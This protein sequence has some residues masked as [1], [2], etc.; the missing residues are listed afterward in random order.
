MVLQEL[1]KEILVNAVQ[2]SKQLCPIAV[3]LLGNV[4]D[5]S[6]VHP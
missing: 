6:S 1:G 3:R 4:T 2:P 5:E